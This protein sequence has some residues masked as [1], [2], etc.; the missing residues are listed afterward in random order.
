M[1]K[2]FLFF[3]KLFLQ[4]F[5][6]ML[7]GFGISLGVLMSVQ[8]SMR[9]PSAEE[10]AALD[11]VTDHLSATEQH[12]VKKSRNSV[13]RILSGHATRDGM[14]TMSGTYLSHDNRYYVLTAAHGIMGDC[15]HF[16]VAT[17]DDDLYDCIRYITIDQRKDYAVI[18]IEKVTGRIPLRLAQVIPSNSEW[19]SQLAILNKTF[20]TGYPNSIGPLTFDGSVAGLSESQYIYIHSYAWPGSSGAGVFARDGDLIGIVLALNVGVTGAGYDVLEDVVIVLPLFKI[21]WELIYDEMSEPPPPQDT[22]DTAE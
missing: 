1:W 7:L 4:I 20:Y 5:S 11:N 2:N 13:L 9:L 12:T 22:G 19:K 3:L 10:L 16:F 18:E 17:G 8:E 6:V 15:E 14:A 21:D